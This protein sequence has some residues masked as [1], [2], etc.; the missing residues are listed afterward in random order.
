MLWERVKYAAFADRKHCNQMFILM[1]YII[2]SNIQID[3]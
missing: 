1:V 3:P 2:T